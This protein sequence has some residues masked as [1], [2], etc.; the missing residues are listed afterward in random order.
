MTLPQP[1]VPACVRACACRP[2]VLTAASS[3]YGPEHLLRLVVKLPELLAHAALTQEE[4]DVVV[5]Y[6]ND[7]LK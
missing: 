2:E 1:F 5:E 7:L 3:L 6:V 4:H